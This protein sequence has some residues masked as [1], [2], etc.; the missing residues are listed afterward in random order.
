M[1]CS[2]CLYTVA[3]FEKIMNHLP[4]QTVNHVTNV[5]V[6]FSY[7]QV[8]PNISTNYQHLPTNIHTH[9]SFIPAPTTNVFYD[10]LSKSNSQIIYRTQTLPSQ[11]PSGSFHHSPN[12]QPVFH[13]HPQK[14]PFQP[15][16]VPI[17]PVRTQFIGRN[18]SDFRRDVSPVN[19]P[20]NQNSQISYLRKDP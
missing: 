4:F 13:S 12:I 16:S 14:V 5:P 15:T 2:L 3:R 10:P 8:S 20:R 9:P 6:Q 18:I 1:I 19:T 7:S 11:L 17:N